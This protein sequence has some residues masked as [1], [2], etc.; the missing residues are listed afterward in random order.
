MI[1]IHT[2]GEWILI[3]AIVTGFARFS[4]TGIILIDT[5]P[6]VTEERRFADL[7]CAACKTFVTLVQVG[8]FLGAVFAFAGLGAWAWTWIGDW[9]AFSRW[10]TFTRCAQ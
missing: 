8:D 5:S 2:D 9:L 1:V 7:C 4:Q 3:G 10:Q 6:V